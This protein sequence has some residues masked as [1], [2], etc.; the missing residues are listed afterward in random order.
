L[1]HLVKD[2]LAFTLI[3]LESSNTMLIKN[4]KAK[5]DIFFPPLARN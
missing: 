2:R 5:Y 4:F 3:T 1:K